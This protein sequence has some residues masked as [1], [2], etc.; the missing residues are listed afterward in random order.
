MSRC[1]RENDGGMKVMCQG[2]GPR[3]VTKN[4]YKE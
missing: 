2:R 3:W 4:M 1:S